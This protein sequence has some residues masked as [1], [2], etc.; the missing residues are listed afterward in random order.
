MELTVTIG[1]MALTCQ[2]L[3]YRYVSVETQIART[4][5]VTLCYRPSVAWKSL[6]PPKDVDSIV[7]NVHTP[8]STGE[9]EGSHVLKYM[10]CSY[11]RNYEAKS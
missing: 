7:I 9:F 3:R 4:H 6:F 8:G 11:L 5:S 10:R 1:V 2:V